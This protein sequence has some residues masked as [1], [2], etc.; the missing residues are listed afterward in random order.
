MIESY[1]IYHGLE[2]GILI[3]VCNWRKNLMSTIKDLA[4]VHKTFVKIAKK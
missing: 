2:K 4:I 1:I 3:Y